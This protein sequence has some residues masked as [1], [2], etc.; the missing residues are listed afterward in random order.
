MTPRSFWESHS[1]AECRTVAEAAGTNLAN[2]RHIALYDGACSA[3]LA[4]RLEE[5]SGG[6]MTLKEILFG[7]SEAA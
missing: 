4:N 3:Q 2:F 6:V 5:S 1:L 7:G